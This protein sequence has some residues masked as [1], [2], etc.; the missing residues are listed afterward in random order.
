M[1]QDIN[2]KFGQTGEAL[3]IR[4]QKLH[5][6]YRINNKTG[7]CRIIELWETIFWE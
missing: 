6:L 1:V 5:K 3:F 7:V 2:T 4:Y